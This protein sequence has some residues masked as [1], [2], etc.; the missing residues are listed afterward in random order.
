MNNAKLEIPN[1]N[2]YKSEPF[3]NLNKLYYRRKQTIMFYC[4]KKLTAIRKEKKPQRSSNYMGS[5]TGFAPVSS[6]QRV[7]P[8]S[9]LRCGLVRRCGGRKLRLHRS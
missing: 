9:G 2:N 8:S 7:G 4:N 1:L 6:A 3:S 5:P